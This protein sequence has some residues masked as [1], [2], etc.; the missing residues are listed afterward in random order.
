[1]RA[2]GRGSPP[3][4]GTQHRPVQPPCTARPTRRAPIRSQV[5]RWSWPCAAAQS[6]ALCRLRAG[7]VARVEHAE[8]ARYVPWQP[9]TAPPRPADALRA[10][11]IAGGEIEPGPAVWR[12]AR[13]RPNPPRP[14]LQPIT[15]GGE[16]LSGR[17]WAQAASP[18][19]AS[20]RAAWVCTS[21]CAHSPRT[22]LSPLALAQVR[23]ARGSRPPSARRG[24]RR[25]WVATRA[26]VGVGGARGRAVAGGTWVGGR[27]AGPRGFLRPRCRGWILLEGKSGDLGQS[28]S[29]G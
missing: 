10:A 12:G 6:R 5:V 8:I 25:D 16:E 2:F 23:L 28:G 11:R 27:A 21:A 22:A 20:A 29:K 18:P 14:E 9:L 1:M 7:R 15:G 13:C 26:G 3:H 17:T 4:A 19:P 24:R